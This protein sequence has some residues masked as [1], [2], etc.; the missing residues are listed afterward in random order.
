MLKQSYRRRNLSLLRQSFLETFLPIIIRRA[1]R[2]RRQLIIPQDTSL[3]RQLFQHAAMSTALRETSNP[4]P[5]PIIRI[6]NLNPPLLPTPQPRLALLLFLCVYQWR[7]RGFLGRSNSSESFGDDSLDLHAIRD[8]AELGPA[9]FLPCGEHSPQSCWVG[10]AQDV[11][12]VAE[13]ALRP[14]RDRPTEALEP[15]L[16]PVL[17]KWAGKQLEMS[18][19]LE[20]FLEVELDGCFKGGA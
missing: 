19:D 13:D 8:K 20:V 15:D 1:F 11:P 12:E 18:E 6:P 2:I 14:D 17:A 4:K 9:A 7:A 5:V 16:A 3:S 10:I